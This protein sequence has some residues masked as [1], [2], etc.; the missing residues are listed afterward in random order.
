MFHEV[1]LVDTKSAV[2]DRA[3]ARVE[4]TGGFSARAL[5]AKQGNSLEDAYDRFMEALARRPG[6]VVIDAS[7][8]DDAYRALVG[9]LDG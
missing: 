6:A 7:T 9:H 1:T 3:T 5:V 2:L 4:P 8:I